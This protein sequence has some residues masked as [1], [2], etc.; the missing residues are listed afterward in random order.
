NSADLAPNRNAGAPASDTPQSEEKEREEGVGEIREFVAALL[1][2]DPK[3]AY[4]PIMLGKAAE[5]WLREGATVSLIKGQLNDVMRREKDPAKVIRYVASDIHKVLRPPKAV[6]D[7]RA[8]ASPPLVSLTSKDLDLQRRRKAW[9]KQ[10]LSAEK[11]GQ[12]FDEPFPE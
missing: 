3:F 4:I 2:K 12:P 11:A 1:P 5:D 8:E 10:R 7:S 9:H 6:D